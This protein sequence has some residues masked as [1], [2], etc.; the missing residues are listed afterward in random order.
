MAKGTSSFR[1]ESEAGSLVRGYNRAVQE[2]KR[3]EDSFGRAASK[4]SAAEKSLGGMASTVGK[5]SAAFGGLASVS[6]I[7]T[8]I[9]QTVERLGEAIVRFDDEITP[10]LSLGDNVKNATQ[11]QEAILSTSGAYGLAAAE[12]ARLRFNIQSGA[13]SLA[14]SVQDDITA[15]ALNIKKVFG[16]PPEEAA[17]ALFKTKLIFDQDVR[18]ISNKLSFLADR[19]E[20]TFE[21]M[22]RFLP[23]VLPAAKTFGFSLND[24]VAALTVATQVGGRTQ[25]VFTGVRNVFLRMATA[26]TEGI[27]VTGELISQLE[28]LSTVGPDVLKKVF[29]D[30]AVTAIA[31]LVQ[32][33]DLVRSTREDLQGLAG[34]DVLSGLLTK[35]ISGDPRFVEAE[36]FRIAKQ[37]QENLSLTSSTV[38]GAKPS[39][40][41][42]A[43]L[44]TA[45]RLPPF[46]QGW[47]T[48]WIA[49]LS[50]LGSRI[51][52]GGA[53][54]AEVT[55]LNLV[56]ESLRGQ[57]RHDLADALLEANRPALETFNRIQN[58]LASMLDW[59]NDNLPRP[60][61]AVGDSVP[62]DDGIPMVIVGGPG[63]P[64]AANAA[65][66]ALGHTALGTARK[67]IGA[68]T[69]EQLG[70]GG[71]GVLQR[72]ITV[73]QGA[74]VP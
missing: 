56:V 17:R 27:K 30:E 45:S 47:P 33:R 40:S 71:P 7:G 42:F 70:R 28:E 44:G 51:T 4:G 1:L 14:K 5:L 61:M 60:Q 22:A 15:T 24:I 6:A 37:L 62:F 48:N 50:V 67:A 31:S 57:G 32:M 39:A 41:E 69:V 9:I 49:D 10:L 29:G 18:E 43:H 19:G 13:S 34:Q 66:R 74:H 58:T 25:K 52:G 20:L 12:I 72:S 23:D 3:L 8:S 59:I 65:Q 16:A 35:R 21:Q 46:L 2:T 64:L 26:E 68:R 73:Y 63:V 53:G 54:R 36:A 11:L 38:L 55:G